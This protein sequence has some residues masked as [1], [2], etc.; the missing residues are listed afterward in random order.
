MAET[1]THALRGRKILVV[2]DEYLIAADLAATLED[3]GVA[4]VGPAGSVAQALELVEDAGGEL[5]AAVLDV[6]LGGE[7]VY[8]VA[9]ALAA[10]GVP[11]V[12]ATG[13]DHILVPTNHAGVA[14]CEKPVNKAAL[15]RLL[16]NVSAARP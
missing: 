10:R 11:F 9:D 8:P 7:R 16:L 5:D 12:F 3:V 13:Y 15:V 4:V 2:E 1:A 14:R 6:N